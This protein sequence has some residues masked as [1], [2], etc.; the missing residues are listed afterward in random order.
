M[1][2]FWREQQFVRMWR[3]RG[4]TPMCSSYNNSLQSLSQVVG[5]VIGA[6]GS[7]SW[8]ESRAISPALYLKGERQ[9]TWTLA[10]IKGLNA[11]TIANS[12]RFTIVIAIAQSYSRCA[13][14]A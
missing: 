12:Y 8:W 6:N 5:S 11:L 2:P 4:Q 10:A 13:G 1:D 9:D 3:I 14:S 7:V